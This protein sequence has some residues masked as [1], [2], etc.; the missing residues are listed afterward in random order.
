MAHN[1]ATTNGKTATAFYGEM[2]WHQ[3]GTRLDAPATA[4]EAISAAGLDFGVELAELQTIDGI[5]VSQ[6]R[7]VLRTDSSEVIGVVG[8]GYVPVQNRE[9]FGFLDAIVSEGN[10]RYHTA[11]ALGKGERIWLLAKL[12]TQIQV[13]GSDDMVDKFLLLSNTHDGSSALRV[14]FTPIR[15]VCQ[16]TLTMA[17]TRARGQG[18]AILHRGNLPSKIREA[19][20]VLGLAEQFYDDAATKIDCLAGYYPST[21]QLKTFF[22]S[23]YPDPANSENRRAKNVR[24]KLFGLFESGVGQDIPEVRGT[25]WAAFNSVTEYVDHWRSSRG[26]DSFDRASRR[27]ESSWFGSGAKLKTR[28]WNLALEMT[29]AN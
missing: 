13:K 22:E 9:C 7:A 5:P 14:Y 6:K 1:L 27:L 3:L 19:Q 26:S 17:E 4:A 2:P 23:L 29:A 12:P 15:V 11:G 24:E 25:A 28:A 16:N 20:R 18:L 8:T 21:E 10:L